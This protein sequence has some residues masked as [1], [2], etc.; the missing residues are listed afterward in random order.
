MRTFEIDPLAYD[1]LLEAAAWYEGQRDHLG[2]EFIAEVER[3]VGPEAGQQG[4]RDLALGPDHEQVAG[5][6]QR[7]QLIQ[8]LPGEGRLIVQR[9]PQAGG[10]DMLGCL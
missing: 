8:D 4:G 2:D 3:G 6:E 9:R 5:L 7:P 10:R 1:E